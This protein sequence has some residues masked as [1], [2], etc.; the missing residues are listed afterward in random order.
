MSVSVDMAS[1]DD[2]VNFG[3]L[4]LIH[5]GI[6][7]SPGFPQVASVGLVTQLRDQ[8]QGGGKSVD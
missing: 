8:Q 2:Q 5:G 4:P 3:A 6:L 7:C 1:R